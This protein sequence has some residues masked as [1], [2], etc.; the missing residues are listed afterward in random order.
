MGEFSAS[1]GGVS[2]M[3]KEHATAQGDRRDIRAPKPARESVWLF[4]AS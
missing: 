3:L 4:S 2:A 1:F